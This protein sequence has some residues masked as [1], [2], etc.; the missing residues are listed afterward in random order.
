MLDQAVA[1]L[2]AGKQPSLEQARSG[3]TEI[4]LR[5]PALLPDDYI[6]DVS[7]RLS[8][9][10]RIAS[11]INKNQL[12][13][14][15]IEMIDRFG[16]LPDATKNLIAISKLRFKAQKIG[17]SRIDVGPESGL[18]EF[19]DETNVDPLFIIS[20]IQQQPKIYKMI[21]ANKLKFN[22]ITE[23]ATARFQLIQTML[24]ELGKK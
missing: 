1:A 16:L 23:N 17:I 6:F 21:G 10:K 15:Q 4:D 24:N 20:L 8:L 3:Q 14:V 11:C 22:L 2:K 5:I 9:Y 12:D 13:D 19:S 18:I 7:L